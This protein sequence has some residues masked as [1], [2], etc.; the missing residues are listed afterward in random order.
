M[1]RLQAE[2]P[3]ILRWAV[4]GCLM[5]QQEGLEPPSVVKR[6]TGDYRAEMDVIAAFIQDYCVVGPQQ[7]VS[8]GEL[9]ADY[10]GWCQQIGEGAVS[11]KAFAT[12]LRERG[13]RPGRTSNE[14]FWWGIALKGDEPE[15]Q[16]VT[17][18]IS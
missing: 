13:F 4:E 3:G 8:A 17:D 5:W 16:E 2:L 18:D 6:A 9:Y 7:K 15:P 14:R 1:E 10:T 11:Q 12:A